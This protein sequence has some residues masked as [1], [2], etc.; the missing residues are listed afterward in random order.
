M[1]TPLYYVHNMQVFSYEFQERLFVFFLIFRIYYIVY[2]K[3]T[4]CHIDWKYR[5]PIL[6][7]TK[8]SSDQVTESVMHIYGLLS[9][10][11]D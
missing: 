7:D 2:I 11:L 6:M 3:A 9:A 4:D 10:F 8:N 1:K 5:L